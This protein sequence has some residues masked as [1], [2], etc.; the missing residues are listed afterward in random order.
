MRASSRGNK[1]GLAASGRRQLDL[2]DN[3]VIEHTE[4][5]R[6]LCVR[7]AP[8]A[9]CMMEARQVK[10]LE[11]A[12]D[13]EI[14]RNGNI[15]IVPSQSSG[16]R[17]SVNLFIQSCTCLDFEE[18]RTKCK[19]LYAV[20][21]FL[22]RESGA[23]LPT[24][25]KAVKPTYKQEWHAYNLAQTH[26]KAKLQELLYELCQG[27]DAPVQTFGRPRL[28]FAE[29]VF[30]AAFKVYSTV[31]GRRFISDLREAQQ[32][33][34]I[35][36]T[37]HFNSISNYL[38]LEEMTAY[39]KHLITESSLPL[40]SV[41][42]DFAVDSSGFATAKTVRWLHQKY[43]TPH[44]VDKANWLKVHLMCGVKTNVVTSV[45]VSD[46]HAGDSPFFKPLVKVTAQ[47]FVMNEV[48][49][50]KAYLSSGNLKT[51]VENAAMPFIPFKSNSVAHDKRH[52]AL[53]KQ[54]YH[55]YCYNQERFKQ[56]YH[57]RSNVES[58]FSMIKAK[59]GERLR[60]KSRTA[61]TNEILCK[62]LCHNVCCLIQSIYELGIEPEFYP[63]T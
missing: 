26:E 61:Q 12:T 54:M 10:G 43:T 13:H 51:V 60:S 14:T 50:D 41:E 21:N 42:S 57:K 5:A 45:E 30:C 33:G 44:I 36:K 23:T 34:Y 39:L 37:P 53:W 35:T 56:S 48:S 58:T 22:L 11:I 38:E 19:H 46:G 2:F 24:P 3:S 62:I 27:V 32:R 52:S 25:E 47:N 29:M 40:K 4:V 59:F 63:T 31:S 7:R 8:K 49:A 9:R 6:L 15:F 16:K 18:N 17:Y 20:E 55:F 28:P 1:N